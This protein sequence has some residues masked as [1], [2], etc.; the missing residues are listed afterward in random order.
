MKKLGLSILFTLGLS[1]LVIISCC[2][3]EK[4]YWK[5]V[6]MNTDLFSVTNT[7]QFNDISNWSKSPLYSGDTTAADT[8]LFNLR[9]ESIFV[10]ENN[11]SLYHSLSGLNSAF[12]T[13]KCEPG[14]H[15]VKHKAQTVKLT[16]NEEFMGVP[17]GELLND[18]T[19]ISTS[20]NDTT[21]SFSFSPLSVES[22]NHSLRSSNYSKQ[23]H[24]I[25]FAMVK[26]D[27]TTGPQRFKLEVVFENGEV[28]K[29]ETISFIWE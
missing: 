25:P 11:N 19:L 21:N 26:N 15:G 1:S 22:F 8:V 3:E 7:N 14:I 4:K 12:A 18:Y 5:P 2:R 17:S 6:T 13:P 24:M 20:Y 29:C 23:K 28:L 10:A 16:S 27:S 9:L